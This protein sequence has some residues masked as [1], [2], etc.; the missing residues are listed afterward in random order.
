MNLFKINKCGIL[1]FELSLNDLLQAAGAKR[2][3]AFA[4]QVW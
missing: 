4:K 1:S 2:M 3:L